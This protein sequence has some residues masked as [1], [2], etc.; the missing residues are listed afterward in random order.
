[1]N[2]MLKTIATKIPN[3]LYIEH[4]KFGC[5][6]VDEFEDSAQHCL[7]AWD[8]EEF[9]LKRSQV[10]SVQDQMTLMSL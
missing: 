1:M 8:T 2:T 9:T 7:I 3:L 10:E 4:S 5:A 6:N